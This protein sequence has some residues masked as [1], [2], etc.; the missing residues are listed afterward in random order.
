MSCYV[1]D[2]GKNG[3]STLDIIFLH[4]LI[5]AAVH[6]ISGG[7]ILLSTGSQCAGVVRILLVI[8]L[9]ICFKD[10]YRPEILRDRVHQGQQIFLILSVMFPICWL[11]VS[12]RSSI[13]CPLLWLRI[14][15]SNSICKILFTCRF[16]R[17]KQ[18]TSVLDGVE[19]S[20]YFLK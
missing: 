13:K 11:D 14:I 8:S 15:P 3:R 10:L 7:M 6:R 19:Y 2:I 18:Q 20:L 12:G 4:P 5:R 17:W 1:W 9:F 16:D